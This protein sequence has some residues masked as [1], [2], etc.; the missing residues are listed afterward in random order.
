M[1]VRNVGLAA[2]ALAPP[3]LA[4]L[5]GW[6][7]PGWRGARPLALALGLLIPGAVV[8]TALRERD[9]P[10]G[11]GVDWSVV[12]S[13]AAAF[14]RPLPGPHLNSWDLGG[15]LDLTWGGAPPTFLDG[16]LI[17]P[18]RGRDHDAVVEATAPGPTL[19]RLG[20]RTMLLQPLYRGDGA[21]LQVVPWLL[22][23]PGWALVR[24]SDGL[25]F[26]RADAAAGLERLPASAGWRLVAREAERAWERS[27]AAR[28][29]PFVRTWALAE[30]GERSAAAA[31]F[32]E[33][34][35]R[36]PATAPGY[37]ALAP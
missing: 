8:V 23:A 34:A 27:R 28:H 2:L 26:V 29:A 15:W 6:R 22:R 21:L 37:S 5:D 13:D 36:D 7:S 9:P 35:A 18:Q 19:D 25:V 32:R 30:L 17:D 14:A 31:A 1:V 11:L 33:A 12:A 20:V 3:A 4:G 16:R 10:P 24:A